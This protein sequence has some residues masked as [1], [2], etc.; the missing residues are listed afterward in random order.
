MKRVARDFTVTME[1]PN[2]VSLGSCEIVIKVESTTYVAKRKGFLGNLGG[3]N[4]HIDFGPYYQ[5][6]KV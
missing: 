4:V 3:K 5:E 6:V 1:V 2:N